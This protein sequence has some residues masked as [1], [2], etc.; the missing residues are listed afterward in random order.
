[1]DKDEKSNLCL[2]TLC[3]TDHVL[4]WRGRVVPWPL[5]WPRGSLEGPCRGLCGPPPARVRTSALRGT[6]DSN[7][8]LMTG[9]Q[10]QPSGV[11]VEFVSLQSRAPTAIRKRIEMLGLCCQVNVLRIE[12][13]SRSWAGLTGLLSRPRCSPSRDYTW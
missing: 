12:V 11:H 3:V 1:M 5:A 8:D 2:L 6:L 9:L 10:Y 13:L 7:D 4:F